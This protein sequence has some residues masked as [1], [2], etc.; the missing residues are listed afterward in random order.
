MV[1]YLEEHTEKNSFHVVL[2]QLIW[3]DTGKILFIL[4]LA[5]VL[6]EFPNSLPNYP[7]LYNKIQGENI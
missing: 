5:K 2:A 3:G 6:K 7:K 4:F 1:G